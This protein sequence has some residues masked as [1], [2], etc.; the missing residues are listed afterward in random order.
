MGSQRVRH[1]WATEHARRE[2]K[3]VFQV[4]RGRGLYENIWVRYFPKL[5]HRPYFFYCSWI[6]SYWILLEAD[7]L[8][9]LGV[10]M[11]GVE[12][13]QHFEVR[14]LSWGPHSVPPDR[15]GHMRSASPS[16]VS[17]PYRRALSYPSFLLTVSTRTLV[18]QMIKNLPTMLET[19]VWSL[20]QE[21]PLGKGKATHSSILAWRIPWGWRVRHDWATSTILY[22]VRCIYITIYIRTRRSKV[23][24]YFLIT[25]RNVSLCDKYEVKILLL[26]KNWMKVF[27]RK[28][29]FKVY[30]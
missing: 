6:S 12:R 19:W 30:S 2:C 28:Y 5:K 20:G 14:T 16:L 8:V 23:A 18:A 24:K 7:S 10:V 25:C 22:V 15:D 3:T 11:R 9:G 27:Y 17:D 21:D 4:L 26:Q 13:A 1:E 29:N